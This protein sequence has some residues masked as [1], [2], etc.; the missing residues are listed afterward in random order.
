MTH[1]SAPQANDV[2]AETVAFL[3]RPSS[4]AERP[5]SVEAIETHMAWVFLAGGSAYKLK[6]PIR[7]P[8]LNFGTPEARRRDA[9]EEVRLNRRL[10]PGVYRGVVRL[11]R[12]AN[13]RLTFVETGRTVDWLVWMRRL[14]RDTMLDAKIRRQTLTTADIHA[15]ADRLAEFYRG[16]TPVGYDPAAYRSRFERG[17]V[18]NIRTLRRR[19]YGLDSHLVDDMEAVLQEILTSRGDLLEK[20]AAR[21]V[22]GHGDLR[23]EHICLEAPPLIIDCLAFNREFRLLDPADECAFL[24]LECE[25]LG[26]PQVGPLLQDAYTQATGDAPDPSVCTFYRSYRAALRAKL[27][28]WHLD[29]EHVP[30]PNVWREQAEAYLRFGVAADLP[31][32]PVREG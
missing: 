15:V 1:P 22:E 19:E 8:F 26:A 28:V 10:A 17:A 16:L 20:R 5:A 18:E 27:A 24:A 4:Y 32:T 14:A 3:K 7:R 6:K 9:T 12:D 13:G 2:L 23:P 30:H 25:I 11:S 21:V 31:A 29:D